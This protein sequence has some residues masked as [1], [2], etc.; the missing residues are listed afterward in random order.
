MAAIQAELIYMIMRVVDE[1]KEPAGLNLEM[2][3]T[4]KVN[5][6]Q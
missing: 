6:S 2:L 3:K 4:F 1:T 5:F